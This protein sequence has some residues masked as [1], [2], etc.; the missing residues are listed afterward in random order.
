M[1]SL[2]EMTA[3]AAEEAR[4]LA[5][6]V[7]AAEL[8]QSFSSPATY[9]NRFFVNMTP[10]GARLAFGEQMKADADIHMRSAVVLSRY[11]VAELVRI[12]NSLIEQVPPAE[13]PVG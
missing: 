5:E 6:A 9:V 3:A 12:L 4:S 13:P 8:E 2:A 11:D 7:A 1:P 10:Y